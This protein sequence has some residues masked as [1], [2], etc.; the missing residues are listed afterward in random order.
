MIVKRQL[1]W[2]DPEDQLLG[3]AGAPPPAAAVGLNNMMDSV[4]SALR[5]AVF[6]VRAR[7]AVENNTTTLLGIASA[8]GP[9]VSVASSWFASTEETRQGVLAAMDTMSRIID[10]LDGPSRRDVLAG[11]ETQE[12][13]LKGASAVA[14]GVQAQ[15]EYLSDNT[16]SNLVR[17]T[18]DDAP[19]YFW[20][21]IDN[22]LPGIPNPGLPPLGSKVTLYLALAAGA[23]FVIFVLPEL[24]PL[25]L[26]RRAAR[27]SG[28]SRRKRRTR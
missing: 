13:W 19:R 2:F 16:T 7:V 10:R 28:Y 24:M 6:K 20:H 27:M 25:I 12:Q 21:D 14:D 11:T 3:F 1:N 8:A 17:K 18:I 22:A 9:L 23:A 4:V 5:T 26:A 15:L